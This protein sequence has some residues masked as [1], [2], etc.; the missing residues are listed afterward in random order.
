M[1]SQSPERPG[2][3]CLAR[4]LHNHRRRK[5]MYGLH[6]DLS[7]KLVFYLSTFWSAQGTQIMATLRPD[8]PF[9]YLHMAW[10]NGS[11]TQYQSLKVQDI[12]IPLRQC[13]ESDDADLRTSCTNSKVCV[14]RSV[15]LIPVVFNNNLLFTLMAIAKLAQ[16]MIEW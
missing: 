6:L 8:H 4:L 1:I 10:N 2:S 5:K 12:S 15:L 16:M 7:P 3:E 11:L 14:H 13:K 9:S